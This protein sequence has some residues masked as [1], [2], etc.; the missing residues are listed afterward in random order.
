LESLKTLETVTPMKA[1]LSE[2]LNDQ[3]SKGYLNNLVAAE[4]IISLQRYNLRNDVGD[5]KNMRVI[6]RFHQNFFRHV[7]LVLHARKKYQSIF[8]YRLV[9]VTSY[10]LFILSALLPLY[11]R[12]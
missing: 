6:I 1:P 12:T 10:V 3:L 8:T 7:I 2:H 11:A 4:L 9:Y 5:I